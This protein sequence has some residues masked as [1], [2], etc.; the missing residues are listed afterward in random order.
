M[1]AGYD[2]HATAVGHTL[3]GR[4]NS[5]SSTPAGR[6]QGIAPG[7]A[8]WTGSIAT[9]FGSGGSFNVTDQ[10]VG[11]TGGRCWAGPTVPARGPTW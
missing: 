4:V 8:L 6:Q 5:G 7:A 9:S 10:S 2:D 3:G 1:T 11:R